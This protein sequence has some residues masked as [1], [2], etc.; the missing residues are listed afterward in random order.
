[1][2]PVSAQLADAG[3]ASGCFD[4]VVGVDF[5]LDLTFGF[6]NKASSEERDV[7]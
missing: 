7:T 4:A 2:Y 6:G 5:V 3:R 1:M